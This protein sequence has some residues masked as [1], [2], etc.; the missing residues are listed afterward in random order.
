MILVHVLVM[1]CTTGPVFYCTPGAHR[2]SPYGP[3]ENLYGCVL[4][5]GVINMFLSL[6]ALSVYKIRSLRS[7]Q[8]LCRKLFQI[9]YYRKSFVRLNSVHITSTFTNQVA[10]KK[11]RNDVHVLQGLTVLLPYSV[12]GL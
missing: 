10:M 7:E 3:W 9:S 1:V 6:C 11:C 8:N 2:G 12:Q 4:C 5:V